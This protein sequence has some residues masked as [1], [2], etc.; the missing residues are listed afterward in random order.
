M[1]ASLGG[2]CDD[3][4]NY[5]TARMLL[6]LES[7][8]VFDDDNYKKAIDVVIGSY[9]RDYEDHPNDFRPT[10]LANDIIRFWKTL[11][12]NYEHK[13]NQPT[14]DE[15]KRIRQK[16]KNFKLKFSRLFTCYATIGLLSC[17]K[18]YSK[19]EIVSMIAL[20]PIQRFVNIV[21]VFP[22]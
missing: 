1:L 21:E 14:D 11:C 8:P 7:R 20:P 5:F 15:T 13:R 2:R 9:M 16:I 10:F 17:H 22:S 6:I 3:Y 19:D 18:H 12:L 4:S